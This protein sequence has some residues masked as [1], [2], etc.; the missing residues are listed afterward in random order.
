MKQIRYYREVLDA[1]KESLPKTS[2]SYSLLYKSVEQARL[3]LGNTL[4][5]VNKEPS[6]YRKASLNRLNG[7]S[8][9]IPPEQ[10]KGDRF[11]IPE[12]DTEVEYIDYIRE[13]LLAMIE[14]VEQLYYTFKKLI[15]DNMNMLFDLY[16]KSAL[17]DLTLARN[18][19]GFVL[20]DIA[21]KNEIT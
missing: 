9:Y 19:G 7:D 8:D 13:T 11:I 16:I 6:V 1:M 2:R 10:D 5:Y 15:K 12:F 17:Q 20:R 21:N 18:Y 14:E 4:K 3:N